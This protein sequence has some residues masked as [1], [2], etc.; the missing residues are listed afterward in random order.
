MRAIAVPVREES[1]A[2]GLIQPNDRVDVLWTRRAPEGSA[3]AGTATRTILRGAK[4]LAIGSSTEA[5]S[6]QQ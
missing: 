5:K 3:D 1:A 4:V 6:P 2:G